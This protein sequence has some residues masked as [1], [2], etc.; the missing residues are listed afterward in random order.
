LQI[1]FRPFDIYFATSIF[2]P[3]KRVDV[4]S[5]TVTI[6]EMARVH[7]HSCFPGG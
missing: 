3:L 2:K 4:P 5:A 1:I 7:R 6:E